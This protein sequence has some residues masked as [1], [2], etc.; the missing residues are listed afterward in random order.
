MWI[1]IDGMGLITVGRI[2][3]VGLA[4]S[5]PIKRLLA[6]APETKVINLTGSRKRRT[7]AILDSGHMVITPLSVRQ[8]TYLLHRAREEV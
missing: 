2:V 1:E 4:E 6:H 3:A 8:I 5:A 7:V